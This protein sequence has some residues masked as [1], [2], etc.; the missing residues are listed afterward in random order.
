ML[1]LIHGDDIA[2]SRNF[3]INL[4][5]K[6]KDIPILDGMSVSITDLTQILE[7]G[8]LFNEEK[9]VFIENFFTKKKTTS[10]YKSI[11]N[12]LKSISSSA[13]V[14][15]WEAK[16]I[17]NSVI[18]QLKGSTV[19]VFKLPQSLFAFLDGIK[20]GNG[21]QLVQQFHDALVNSNEDAIFYMLIRQFRFLLAFNEKF[22]LELTLEEVKRM[23][24]WQKTKIQR[25]AKLFSSVKLIQ[26][27]RNLLAVEK[28]YKTGGLPS[29]LSNSIDILLL[30][31]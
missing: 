31:V 8:G 13:D 9:I 6:Y 1:T 15:V 28:A 11:L 19:R 3:L 26:T 18:N 2:A 5:E 10:E 7:G 14:I 12:F 30:G 22:N 16:L 24:D 25:Q 4:K 21:K 23:Q 29:S 17:E 27:Y 20:P